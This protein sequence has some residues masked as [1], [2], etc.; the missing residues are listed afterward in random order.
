MLQVRWVVFS[1]FDMSE[2]VGGGK[3]LKFE[4]LKPFGKKL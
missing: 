3:H 4:N 2:K 1:L